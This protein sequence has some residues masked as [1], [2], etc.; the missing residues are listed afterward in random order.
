MYYK[1]TQKILYINH[2]QLYYLYYIYL[3]IKWRTYKEYN[4]LYFY[5]FIYSNILIEMFYFISVAYKMYKYR[6]LATE[7]SPQ[8]SERN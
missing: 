1:E 2:A 5:L 8:D 7:K 6:G 3:P 4:V